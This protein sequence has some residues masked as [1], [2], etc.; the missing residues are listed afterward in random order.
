MLK[1]INLFTVDKIFTEVATKKLSTNAK[2]LYLNCL[3]HYFK[4]KKPTVVNAVTFDLFK[5]D[6]PNYENYQRLF[7]ELHT[8]ELVI[9]RHDAVSFLNTWGK[10]IDRTQLEKVTAD[11]YVAGFKFQGVNAFIEEMRKSQTLH[12]LCQMKHKISLRQLEML[13]DLFYR[14]QISIEKKYNGYTDCA[15]HFINWI[16]TNVSKVP[17]ESIKSKSKLLGE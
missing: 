12:E 2:M 7:E 5:N 14:E 6:I 9:L 3:T 16:P 8:A 17:Q 10:Y 11:T 13:L 4:D 15:K 1:V